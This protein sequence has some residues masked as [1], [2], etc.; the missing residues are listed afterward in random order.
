VMFV[1]FNSPSLEA[2]F[3]NQWPHSMFPLV[4]SS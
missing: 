4:I 3:T 1:V 2:D